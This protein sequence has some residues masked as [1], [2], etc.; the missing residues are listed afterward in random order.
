MWLYVPKAISACS[1]A[2]ERS[3]WLSVGSF[4]EPAPWLMWRGKPTQ[5]PFSLP[6]WKRATWTRLLSGLTSDPSGS[7]PASSKTVWAWWLA[8]FPARTSASP[9]TGPASR[10]SGPGCSLSFETSFA[11]YD[12]A[13]SSWRTSQQS[14]FEDST[15]FSGRWPSSGSMRSGAVFERPTLARHISATAGGASPGTPSAWPTAQ[16]ADGERGSKTLMRGPGNPTLRGAALLWQ[17]PYGFNGQDKDGGYGTGGEFEKSVKLWATASAS[18]AN[19]GEGPKT[20][21]ARQAHHKARG[22][23]GNGMGVPLTIMAQ[24]FGPASHQGP[25]IATAGDDSSPSTPTSRLQLNAKFVAV[26]MGLAPGWISC[27]PSATPSCPSRPR[28]PCACSGSAPSARCSD[29]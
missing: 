3:I 18:V 26:L 24:E 7:L 29:G 13:T 6:G 11:T 23:N 17:T 10:A 28:Q 9:G 8:A 1:A 2:S 5:R 12:P 15:P 21:R 16:A 20:W 4:P 19:E 25:T 22:I 14:L 27:E